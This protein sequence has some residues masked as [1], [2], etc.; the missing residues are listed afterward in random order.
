[1]SNAPSAASWMG[2]AFAI[3]CLVV[4][5]IFAIFGSGVHGVQIALLATARV[6]FL[7]FWAAYAGGALEPLFGGAFRPLKQH[8][9]EF[10]LAFSAALLVHLCLVAR[11]CYLGEAPKPG[12]FVFFGTATLCAYILAIFSLRLFASNA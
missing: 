3:N 12:V 8:G 5:I 6:A 4:A 9:R 11:L 2:A 7:W 10:G 1:M